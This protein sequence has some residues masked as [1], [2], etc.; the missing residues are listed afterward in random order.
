MPV[1]DE[2]QLVTEHLAFWQSYEPAV[3]CDL[4]SCAVRTRLGLVFIDPIP[5]APPAL[6]ELAAAA[7][8]AVILTNG[9][10]TRAA[11]EFRERFSL[12]ILAA[13]EAVP[14]LGI[15]V[16]REISD[17]EVL[18][19]ELTVLAVPGAGPG[20]IA[21][22][23]AAGAMLVGD[24]LIHV[25]P[26]GFSLLPAKYCADPAEMSVGLQKLLRFNFEVLTF[27]H[28]FPI[29]HDARRRLETLLA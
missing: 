14:A 3:K 5:L 20:E 16:D 27:A 9:N 15:A 19:D 28:G 22:H 13:P 8:I 25:E 2:F 7:P 26:H 12:P 1:A 17:G 11:A 18:F 21:L 10:H 24:A 4:S 29:V 6:A 23:F